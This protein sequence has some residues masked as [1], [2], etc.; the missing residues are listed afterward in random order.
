MTYPGNFS[1]GIDRP[2]FPERATA[3]GLIPLLVADG[4]G[5]EVQRPLATVAVGGLVSSTFLTLLVLPA[6]FEWFAISGGGPESL[7]ATSVGGERAEA[8]AL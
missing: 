4:T 1:S 3:L 2:E 7:V 8:G 5:S 6:V